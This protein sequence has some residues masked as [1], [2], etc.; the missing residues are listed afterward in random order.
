LNTLTRD[1]RAFVEHVLA[2]RDG[3]KMVDRTGDLVIAREVG[4]L[5]K[6]LD[7]LAENLAER[8]GIKPPVSFERTEL[9]RE[10]FEAI[11][12]KLA[13]WSGEPVNPADLSTVAPLCPKCADPM[14]RDGSH[15]EAIA[16]HL[17]NGDLAFTAHPLSGV[18][19]CA[20]CGVITV[21][22]AGHR[23]GGAR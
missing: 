8:L 22:H 4:E 13:E 7:T 21:S 20:W 17:P 3:Q 18:W 23:K 2:T 11:Q 19:K 16:E 6:R 15:C 9:T 10:Q 1:V 14:Q 12:A 5:E